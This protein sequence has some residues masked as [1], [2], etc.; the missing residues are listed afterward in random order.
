MLCFRDKTYC[1][2]FTGCKKG[3]LC[4]RAYTSDVIEDARKWWGS[5]EAPIC[6][7]IGKPTCFEEFYEPKSC[8]VK[9]CKHI[10]ET[11]KKYKRVGP[12]QQGRFYK[13]KL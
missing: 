8:D 11:E 12:D 4:S 1:P 10:G 7:F 3:N 6:L 5:E 2:F 13:I 9:N